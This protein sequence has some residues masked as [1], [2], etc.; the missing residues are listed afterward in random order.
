MLHGQEEGVLSKS[1]P[2]ESTMSKISDCWVFNPLGFGVINYDP[3]V[4]FFSLALYDRCWRGVGS[5]NQTRPKLL[6]T[7][8]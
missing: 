8:A 2:N 3:M 4:N 5:N 6:S 1:C 7:V